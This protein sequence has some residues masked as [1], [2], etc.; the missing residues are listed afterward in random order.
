MTGKGE[1]EGPLKAALKARVRRFYRN[2]NSNNWQTCF[3]YLDPKLRQSKI[4]F[5]QYSS[6]L[7]RFADV[8]GPIKIWHMTVH[9]YLDVSKNKQD[10]RSFAFVYIF[11]QDKHQAFHVFKERWVRQG[12]DWYTRVAG[13]ITHEAEANGTA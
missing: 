11:W 2:F 5:P 9:L 7:E 4:N 1:N 6:S 3:E 13:L 8:Y 12:E 10:P